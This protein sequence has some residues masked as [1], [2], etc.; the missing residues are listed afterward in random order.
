MTLRICAV[1]E[2]DVLRT[3]SKQAR[4]CSSLAEEQLTPRKRMRNHMN[5]TLEKL[6]DGLL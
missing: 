4:L 5:H 6:K 3:H 2:R 1:P